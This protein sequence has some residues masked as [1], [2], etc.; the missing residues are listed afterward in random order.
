MSHWPIKVSLFINY[1]VFA[2]LLN[3]VGTVILQVQNTYQISQS[4]A[5]VLEAFKDLPIAITSFLVAS[6]IARI[7]Y[8]RSM[9][10]ALGFIGFVCLVMPHVPT[11]WMTKL[12]FAATGVGFALVKV[13]VFAT[14]GLVTGSR[15]EHVSL[16][17]F[18]ESFFMVGILSGYF[19]FSAYVDDLNPDSTD[20][21]QVYYLLATMSFAA[22]VL[23]IF[24][25]L[26]ESGISTG[27]TKSPAEDFF[28]MIALGIRPLVLVFIICA[29]LYVLIEQS[30]MSWLPTFNSKVLNLPA[31]LSIQ[32]ASI[33]AASTAL[34]RFVAGITLKRL[35]W[36]KVLFIGLLLAAILVLVIL[37][38]AGKGAD[39]EIT[40]W[41]DAPVAAFIFP[42]IGFCIAPVYPAINSVILSALPRRQHAPMSGLIVVFS[43]LGGTLGSI[44][45]GN[46]FEFVGGETAFYFSL[47]PI[48]MLLITLYLFKRETD[49]IPVLNH[50]EALSGAVDQSVEKSV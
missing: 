13:S 20:W 1:F 8:R 18:L 29:F 17:N 28:D 23:L 25:P 49:K 38:L 45:T 12:L 15:K 5:S 34:G 9:L 35:D 31:S 43:A 14:L 47:V 2:I 32:M 3:S 33:L 6:F 50:E 48:S 4:A 30:I 24:A 16:M 22:F 21:L 37:P 27:G 40:G 26:D 7:G 10:F 41:L 42:L 39:R 19:I 44:I 36:F 11:F 46:L